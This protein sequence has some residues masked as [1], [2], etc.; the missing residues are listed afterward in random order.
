MTRF[1]WKEL[2]DWAEKQPVPARNAIILLLD[3]REVIQEVSAALNELAPD[4]IRCSRC[5]KALKHAYFFEGW[6]YGREC[7]K[8]VDPL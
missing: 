6:P 8:I 1:T 7:I 5:G 2:R 3:E 4:S